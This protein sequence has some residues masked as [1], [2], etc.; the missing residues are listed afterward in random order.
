LAETVNLAALHLDA[1]D[2]ASAEP[3]LRQVLEQR[4]DHEGARALF[5]QL[6][7]RGAPKFGRDSEA[8]TYDDYDPS[9]PLP[10]YDL[11]EVSADQALQ[12][13][14]QSEAPG[15]ADGPLPSFPLTAEAS[16]GGLEDLDEI[17]DIEEL[18]P[19]DEALSGGGTEIDALEQA[20][21]EAEFFVVRGL[22]ED[23]RAI[24]QEQLNRTPNHPLVHERLREI[25]YQ[26]GR[27]SGS[28]TID[29]S[30][31]G[32]NSPL[33]VG[34]SL[35]ALDALELAPGAS[36][37]PPRGTNSDVDADQIFAKFKAGIRA[38]VSENDSATHYDLGVAYKEMGLVGDAIHELEVAARDPQ[39]EC[40]CHAMIGMI[41][42]EQNALD[43]AAES[44]VRALSASVKSIEQEVNLYYDLG[45]VFEMKGKAKDALYYFQKIARRDPGYRDVSDRI[46]SLALEKPTREPSGTR[47]VNDDDEFERVFDD[48]FEGKS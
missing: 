16:D 45:N 29:R 14:A 25:D 31:L 34:A 10:S 15:A 2:A 7:T 26:L 24:L 20:L 41:H 13:R 9:A 38:Q 35:D 28:Q 4:P 36:G 11:E 32:S 43:R 12:R 39:R 17:S 48:L 18:P 37:R 42:L 27:R 23:A 1:G 44:Y 5:Q 47:A 3:L 19:F 40:M 46:A 22:F 6:D 21:E 33:D 8:P 30:L